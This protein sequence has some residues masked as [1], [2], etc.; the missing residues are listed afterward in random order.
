MSV[1][2]NDEQATVNKVLEQNQR[3]LRSIAEGDWKAYSELCDPGITG[4]EPEAR[5]QWVEGMA[6][7]KFYFDLDGGAGPH[8]T[9]MCSPRVQLLDNAAVVCYVRLVQRLDDAGKPVTSR[10][11]ETRIWRCDKGVWRHIHFHRSTSG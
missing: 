11:E 5:G 7:H 2:T 3:L 4:F 8:N 9:T 1:P 6:F 10:A